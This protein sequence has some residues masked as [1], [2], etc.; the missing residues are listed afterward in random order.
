MGKRFTTPSLLLCVLVYFL[1]AQAWSADLCCCFCWTEVY[2]SL[3]MKWIQQ[4]TLGDFHPLH[5]QHTVDT[6]LI[7]GSIQLVWRNLSITSPLNLQWPEA[8]IPQFVLQEISVHE[9]NRIYRNSIK[10]CNTWFLMSTLHASCLTFKHNLSSFCAVVPFLHISQSLV[11]SH[12][13][14]FLGD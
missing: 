10:R 8:S 9:K 5:W 12:S 1:C 7:H 13:F 11:I 2:C 3:W 6:V 14:L 4:A